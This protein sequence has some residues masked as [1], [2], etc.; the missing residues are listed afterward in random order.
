MS[1]DRSTKGEYGARLAALT[2][3]DRKAYLLAG[4]RL[5]GPRANLELLAAAVEACSPDELR[6][7]AALDLV[8]AP[9]NTP[10]EFLAVV[11]AAGLGRLVAAGNTAELTMLRALASDPRWRVR[12]GVA[13]ALQRVGAADMD[14]VL[15]IA[16]EWASGNRYEQRAAVAS[17]AEPPLLRDPAVVPPA[18]DVFDEITASIVGAQD[19]RSG[20]FEVLTKALGYGWSVLVAAAPAIG[21]P[22]MERWLGSPD[23]DVRRVMRENLGKARLERADREWAA[24]WRARLR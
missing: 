3:P 23:P 19:R 5:P 12:E 4:S 20:G 1:R 8:A 11:G 15:E 10:D 16:R 14:A 24:A 21:K 9:P 18:L 6:A 13:M 17:L 7:W 2:G 22:R